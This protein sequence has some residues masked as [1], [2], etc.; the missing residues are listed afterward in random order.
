MRN[1]RYPV[2]NVL[3]PNSRPIN[4]RCL[5]PL[6]FLAMVFMVSW[7]AEARINVVTLP[8]RDTVQLTIYNSVDL[9]LVRETRVLTFRK[10]LNRLGFSWANTLIDPTS[11]EFRALTHADEIEVLDVSFPPRVAN[12]LEWRINSE[13][14]GEVQV[15]IRYFTSGIRWSADY[16]LEAQRNEKLTGLA[17][18]VRVTNNS[19][20]DYEEAQVRLVVGIVRLVE[21]IAQLAR[22][23]RKDAMTD[24]LREQSK[25]RDELYFALADAESKAGKLVDKKQIVK[26]GLSEYYLYTVE[27]RDTIPTG[28]SKRLRSFEASDVPITSY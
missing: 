13:F 15:E 10:G 2:M 21:E 19:G 3:F 22:N 27:S 9:T 14:S 28:W 7:R 1:K 16:V 23:G 4:L 25:K 17:G 12:T 5:M 18:Y 26:E 20:E 11:V 6:A 8:G 24:V